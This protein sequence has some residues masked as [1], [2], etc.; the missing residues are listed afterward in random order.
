MFFKWIFIWFNYFL[1]SWVLSYNVFLTVVES[2]IFTI[3]FIFLLWVVL[4]NTIHV[5]IQS[6]KANTATLVMI[7]DR[8]HVLFN[9]AYSNNCILSF[10]DPTRLATPILASWKFNTW[11]R[12]CRIITLAEYNIFYMNC[13]TVCNEFCWELTAGM[14]GSS[15]IIRYAA[16]L[17]SFE[18]PVC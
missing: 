11:W 5:P 3:P 13:H 2:E 12:G 6:G 10:M 9:S 14:C 16:S 4:S 18:F 8:S 17:S 7:V 1:I 15:Y